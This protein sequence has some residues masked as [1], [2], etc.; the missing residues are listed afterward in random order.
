MNV[1][2]LTDLS[3][4]AQNAGDYAMHFL[5]GIPVHFH[6]LNIGDFYPSDVRK[7]EEQSRE[8]LALEKLKE[9]AGQLEDL[10][11][12][13]QHRFSVHYAENDLVTATRDFVQENKI[14]LIIMGAAHRGLAETT[15]IGNHTYEVI[16]KVRCNLLAVP[17]YAKY[18]DPEKML[19]PIDFSASL[20][21]SIFQFLDYPEILEKADITF[22]EFEKA[23]RPDER[24]FEQLVSRKISFME[25]DDSRIYE[26]ETMLKVQRNYDM[27]A[28]LGKNLNICDRLMHNEHGL[29]TSTSNRLPIMVLHS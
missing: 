9:R 5:Q 11:P 3:K 1:L 16:K 17:D 8:E 7:D 12:D 22:M 21:N 26:E 20:N 6:L 2:I 10:I 19:I 27:I 28:M 4:V 23:D 29:Y 13:R 18:K 25:F 14:D 15:L 24:F